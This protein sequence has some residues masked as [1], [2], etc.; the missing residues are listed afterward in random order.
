MLLVLNVCLIVNIFQVYFESRNHCGGSH[1][2][3]TQISNRWGHN[4]VKTHLAAAVWN[5]SLRSCRGSASHAVFVQPRDWSWEGS[6]DSLTSAWGLWRSCQTPLQL[7]CS[8]SCFHPTFFFPYF[9]L[10]V[11]P[12]LN[13]LHSLSLLGLGN[14]FL[15]LRLSASRRT[16]TD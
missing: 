2:S 11:L 14:C 3:V 4:A 9:F 12:L 16:Q 8:L 15:V 1:E 13:L 6:Y 10:P 5:P 7:H